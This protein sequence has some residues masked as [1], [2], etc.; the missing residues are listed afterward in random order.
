M[1][2]LVFCFVMCSLVFSCSGFTCKEKKA[3]KEIH[4][5]LKER[6]VF[7]DKCI[8][9]WESEISKWKIK[10]GRDV[11][12]VSEVRELI[13]K[14]E[15]SFFSQFVREIWN[16]QEQTGNTER[17]EN[18]GRWPISSEQYRKATPLIFITKFDIIPHGCASTIW[19]EPSILDIFESDNQRIVE[20]HDAKLAEPHNKKWAIYWI[21]VNIGT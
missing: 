8:S 19:L 1:I 6:F 17:R 15:L 20:A 10:N 21:F 18:I 16:Y 2:R 4:N 14:D 13:A 7:T 5:D 9:F 11:R 3:T 12:S